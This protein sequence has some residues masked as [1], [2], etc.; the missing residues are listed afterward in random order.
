MRTIP[1]SSIKRLVVCAM[2]AAISAILGSFLKI[3]LNLFGVYSLKVSLSMIP[4][5]LV[6]F[7]Y[8][9]VYGA[10][11]GAVADIIA[12]MMVPMG[13]YNP[14]FTI[15]G[16]MLGLVPGLFFA[17]GQAVTLKRA[18]LATAVGQL[19]GS[20]LLNSVF[21]MISYGQPWVIMLPRLLNQCFHIP[22]LALSAFLLYNIL[23]KAG[24]LEYRP[25]TDHKNL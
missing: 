2:L 23:V 4:V 24:M 14:L 16:M 25:L 18:I 9:P 1:T 12:V 21:L 17:K 15:T 6:A 7:A 11:V 10:M 13:G 19:F 3:P 22:V 8:G 20:V 5:L